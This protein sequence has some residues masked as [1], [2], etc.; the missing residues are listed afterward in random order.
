MYSWL[1][2]GGGLGSVCRTC[3]AINSS[4]P[5]RLEIAAQLAQPPRHPQV[6]ALHAEGKL[7]RAHSEPH[8][9]SS[10]RDRKT[11]RHLLHVLRRIALEHADADR[12]GIARRTAK[13]H[14]GKHAR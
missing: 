8:L 10:R 3:R 12:L 1:Y 4:L 5:I 7:P 11:P 14:I 9:L 13:M 6:V 2:S